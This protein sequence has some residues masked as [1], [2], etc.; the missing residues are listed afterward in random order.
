M[1]TTASQQGY[2]PIKTSF[3]AF[4]IRTQ[5][6]FQFIDLTDLVVEHV[7]RSSI[8]CGLVSVQTMHTTTALFVNENEPLL[9][10]DLR[11]LL[12]RLAPRRYHYRH[13][14]FSIRTHHLLPGETQNGHSHCKAFLLRTSETLS[15]VDGVLPLG[16]WQRV[17][18]V[19]LDSA[20]D[21]TV[22]IL[23]IGQAR[24]EGHG[25]IDLTGRALA[26]TVSDSYEPT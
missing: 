9:L 8:F 14:D 26:S 6:C 25:Q 17:F 2:Q 24:P 23:A 22:S 1:I 20:R 18:L 11:Q 4:H 10:E 15:V 12:E 7:R 21:R 13:D 16:P 5:Q 19:E 3:D